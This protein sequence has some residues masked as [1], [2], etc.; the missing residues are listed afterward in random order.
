ME[1]RHFIVRYEALCESAY[2]SWGRDNDYIW[3]SAPATNSDAAETI[4][5]L[6]VSMRLWIVHLADAVIA[7]FLAGEMMEPENRPQG[8][9]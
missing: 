6:R 7:G 1:V 4:G 9:V 8:L 2:Q 5:A 3:S